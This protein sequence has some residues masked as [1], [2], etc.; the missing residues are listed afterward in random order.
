MSG[1]I[2]KKDLK[3]TG[4]FAIEL[5][6]Y[7]FPF[8][9]LLLQAIQFCMGIGCISF[10][11]DKQ[12]LGFL[13]LTLPLFLLLQKLSNPALQLLHLSFVGGIPVV[14]LHGHIH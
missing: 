9:G 13:K 2:R 11:S 8:G 12:L 10:G 1:R 14:Q 3:L 6:N 7:N 4:E 5:G